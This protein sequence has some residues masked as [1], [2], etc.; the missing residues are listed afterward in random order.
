VTAAI[1]PAPPAGV[2]VWTYVGRDESRERVRRGRAG[3][4][5]VVIQR[6]YADLVD[7]GFR[8]L[9]AERFARYLASTEAPPFPLRDLARIDLPA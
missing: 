9:G 4:A 1:D 2:R 6:A 7:R 5:P 3:G 8:A